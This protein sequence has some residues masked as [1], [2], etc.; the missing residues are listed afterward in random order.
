MKELLTPSNQVVVFHSYAVSAEHTN[1]HDIKMEP[2]YTHPRECRWE[3]IVQA[4]CYNTAK[5]LEKY[6]FWTKILEVCMMKTSV[7]KYREN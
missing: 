1:D 2:F 4:Y 7:P 5:D 3:Q 6:I